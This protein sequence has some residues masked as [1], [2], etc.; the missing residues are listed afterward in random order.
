M[1]TNLELKL[2]ELY[3][4]YEKLENGNYYVKLDNYNEL[5]IPATISTDQTLLA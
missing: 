3:G 5:F 2:Q 1:Q 4:G